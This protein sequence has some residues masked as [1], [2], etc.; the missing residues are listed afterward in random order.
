V[1][2][3]EARESA[4]SKFDHDY[5]HRCAEHEHDKSGAYEEVSGDGKNAGSC[6]LPHPLTANILTP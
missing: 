4:R 1:L 6:A 2:A 5:E 3:I